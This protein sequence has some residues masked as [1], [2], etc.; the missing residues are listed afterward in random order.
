MCNFDELIADY[1]VD[2][3]SIWAY[4]PHDYAYT[5]PEKGFKIHISATTINACYIFNH[6][7][8]NLDEERI[9][10]KVIS[11]DKNL[12]LLNS[13]D[14]GYSQIGKFITVYPPN[15][16]RFSEL[17][18]KLYLATLGF[19]SIDIPSD[20]RYKNSSVVFYRYG[21]IM[22]SE[23][24][25]NDMRIREI[26]EDIIVPVN[27]FYVKRYH[28]MPDRYVPLACLRT[29][30]K[31]RVFQGISTSDKVPIIIKEGLMLGE[32]SSSGY[33]GANSIMQEQ[34]ILAALHDISAFPSL[35]DY[36]YIDK[37]F[38]VIEELKKGKTLKNIFVDKDFS[39]I[40]L[41][42]YQILSQLL[43]LLVILHSKRILIGDLSPDNII[44]GDNVSLSLIDLEYYTFYSQKNGFPGTPGFWCKKYVGQKAI[45]YAFFSI[46]YY[47]SF[48]QE[49][50][51]IS[52]SH[53]N[54]YDCSI[55]KYKS[56]CN[57]VVDIIDLD[58]Y[59]Q[60]L[61]HLRNSL[62]KSEENNNGITDA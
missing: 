12:A 5:L 50:L 15:E 11:S 54:M 19:Q 8:N 18:E 1:S 35:I 14:F 7:R 9:S 16:Q 52:S 47:L 4:P 17:L 21:E 56:I 49:Y 44:L 53:V 22:A 13:G 33:D 3:N 61:N 39:F 60:A 48:P 42:K 58:S 26:P 45:L 25:S 30:G 36:F 31:S 43:E 51:A 57:E 32:V 29:R 38:V 6:V 20:F 28:Q 34:S 55:E 37:S 59:D 10:Y 27:D 24:A 41:H 2:D 62:N 46:W 23:K 40:K